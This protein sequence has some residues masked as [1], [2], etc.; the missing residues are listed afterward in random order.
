M[1]G[2]TLKPK[3][4]KK[5]KNSADLWIWRWGSFVKMSDKSIHH[6]SSLSYRVQHQFCCSS[7]LFMKNK[8]F[9]CIEHQMRTKYYTQVNKNAIRIKYWLWHAPYNAIKAVL[10]LSWSSCKQNNT[11]MRIITVTIIT[12]SVLTTF[13]LQNARV[14][15]KKLHFQGALETGL[16]LTFFF[17]FK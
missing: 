6:K 11:I 15:E 14:E 7:H 8:L 3:E 17:F 2:W 5:R 13:L 9:Q 10:W 12:V 1:W 16:I 4:K